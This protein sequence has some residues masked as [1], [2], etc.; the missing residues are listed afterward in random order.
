MALFEICRVLCSYKF[1][2][3]VKMYKMKPNYY[4]IHFYHPNEG[5]TILLGSFS[6][7]SLLYIKL[8]NI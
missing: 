3:R 7:L 6:F 8:S 5:G 4:I 1:A 2:Q